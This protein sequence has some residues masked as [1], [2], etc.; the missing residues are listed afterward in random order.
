[1][2]VFLASK[3]PRRLHLLQAAGLNVDVHPVHIDE[4]LLP[5]E[6]V[7]LAVQRLAQEKAH[8]LVADAHPVIA[9][10]TL[11]ALDGKALGQPRDKQHALNMLKSLAGRRHHVV[12]GVCVGQHGV[13]LHRYVRT[14]VHFC[15]LSEAQILAYLEHNEVMDKAGAYE[16]QGGAASFVRFVEG[17][18]D[19]VI[20]LPVHVT[21]SLLKEVSV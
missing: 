17:P 7:T 9:A 3:S 21:L 5:D 8:A 16:I 12:T 10:D 1:M 15:D 20:G 4:T 2:R 19:N 13:F 6:D 18:L 11:V 14:E